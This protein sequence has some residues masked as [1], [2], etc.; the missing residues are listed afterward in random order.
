MRGSDA[1]EEAGGEGGSRRGQHGAQQEGPER[2]RGGQVEGSWASGRP[3]EALQKIPKED[4]R[5]WR[6]RRAIPLQPH[7]GEKARPRKPERLSASPESPSTA[8]TQTSWNSEPTRV[9]TALCCPPP[10]SLPRSGTHRNLSSGE[11][12][13]SQPATLPQHARPRCPDQ[14]T[15]VARV[16]SPFKPDPDEEGITRERRARNASYNLHLGHLLMFSQR[17][18]HCWPSSFVGTLSKL[19]SNLAHARSGY[20]YEEARWIAICMDAGAVFPGSNPVSAYLQVRA[21]ISG[22]ALRQKNSLSTC[23]AKPRGGRNQ[24][25]LAAAS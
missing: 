18:K 20:G 8:G 16:A 13:V 11:G 15:R 12:S 23:W 1:W 17:D 10:S 2:I 14:L 21:L 24:S 22:D 3:R 4:E 5:K 7:K 25:A 19:G 9:A 6:K